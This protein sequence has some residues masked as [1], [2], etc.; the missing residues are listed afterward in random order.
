M[1]T[2]CFEAVVNVVG[3]KHVS[4]VDIG[5]TRS[6][7]DR[8]CSSLGTLAC[9]AFPT[10]MAS[11]SDSVRNTLRETLRHHLFILDNPDVCFSKK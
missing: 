11:L 8:R 10:K 7:R 2:D 1:T 3:E 9:K 6:R 4:V 5:M